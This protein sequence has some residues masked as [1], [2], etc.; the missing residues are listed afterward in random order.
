M[1]VKL[2]ILNRS[3]L[4]LFNKFVII[5]NTYF[6]ISRISYLKFTKARKCNHTKQQSTKMAENTMLKF[7]LQILVCY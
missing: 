6:Y 1:E 3:K 4:T 5:N 7:A 2:P